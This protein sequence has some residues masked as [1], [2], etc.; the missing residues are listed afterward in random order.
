MNAVRFENQTLLYLDQRYLPAKEVWRECTTL[1]QGIQAIKELHVRG[2]PLIGIFACYTLCVA[3][4]C[5]PGDKK[6]FF[7]QFDKAICS[8]KNSRPTA[9]NLAW[10]LERVW[11]KARSF[12]QQPVSEIKHA[13]R[14]E[15]KQI[16][17]EDALL[18]QKI[19]RNGTSI[20]HKGACI[21]THC[22]TGFLATG[23]E[24]TALGIIYKAHRDRK[25]ITVYVDETRPL[26]QGA[27]LTAWE[28]M[29]QK[30]PCML[31]TDNMAASIMRK[32]LIDMVIVGADRIARNGDTANKIGTYSLAV[33]AR[34]HKIPFYVA[35]PFS[36]FD[37]SLKSGDDIPIEQR[38]PDEVRKAG[39]SIPLAPEDVPVYNP[40]FDITPGRLITAII[41]DKGVISPP[42]GRSIKKCLFSDV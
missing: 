33:L 29:K 7:H 5:F 39:G 1:H 25:K 13:M 4:E 10:A 3:L 21:L 23:G 12:E 14:E 30:V 11:R 36:T 35:A 34:S 16:H 32:R 8:L 41:T 42:Y 22:N 17:A 15:S 28:L 24:G 38:D 6:G 19:A 27:R 31:I 2:A 20:V 26:L 18:C 37:L 40:A 9:V